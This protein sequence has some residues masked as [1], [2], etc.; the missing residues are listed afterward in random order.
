VQSGMSGM[1]SEFVGSS[2]I[3]KLKRLGQL[4]PVVYFCY[5]GAKI[6]HFLVQK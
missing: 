6:N 2:L 5:V 1:G 3:Q 4:M